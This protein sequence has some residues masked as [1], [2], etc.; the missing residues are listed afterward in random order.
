VIILNFDITMMITM[1]IIILCLMFVIAFNIKAKNIASKD[2]VVLSGV[3]K[4]GKT[5]EL[6]IGATVYFKEL[7]GDSVTNLYGFYS[8]SVP[9][10]YMSWSIC[11]WG[12]KLLEK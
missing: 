11:L 9:L 7:S 1:R 4:E 6:L 10:E 12:I 5:G 2:L 3:V 8:Y